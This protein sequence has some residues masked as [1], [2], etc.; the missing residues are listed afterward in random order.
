LA[1][2]QERT[3]ESKLKKIKRAA[4]KAGEGEGQQAAKQ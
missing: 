1:Q 3:A 2:A 4:G